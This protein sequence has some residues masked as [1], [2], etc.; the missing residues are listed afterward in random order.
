MHKE[1]KNFD[2][3]G[4]FHITIMITITIYSTLSNHQ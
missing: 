3:N 4:M 2:H 1:R